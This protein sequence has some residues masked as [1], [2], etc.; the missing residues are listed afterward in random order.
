MLSPVTLPCYLTINQSENCAQAD[1]IPW[2]ALPHLAFKNVLLK[3]MR[4]FGV[5]EHE[6]PILL[7]LVPAINAALLFTTQRQ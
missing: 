6:P 4:E 2:N 1:H 7:A 5:L 3:P